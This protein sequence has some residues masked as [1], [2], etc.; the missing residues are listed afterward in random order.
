MALVNLKKNEIQAKIVYYGPGR[1][2]KTTNL[3]YIY[4]KSVKHINSEIVTINTGEGHTLFFDYLP[5]DIGAI[6]GFNLKVQLYTVPGQLK[7]NATR[8][9]LMRGV[10]GVVFVADSMAVRR[11]DNVLSLQ[12]LKEDL[13]HYDK[14]IEK[15]PLVI[16]YNKVDLIEKGIPLLNTETLENDLNQIPETP[17][18]KASARMGINV[19]STLKKIILTTVTSIEK[20]LN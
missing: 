14:R 15:T 18:Y 3:E 2:G 9:V 16:Q 20:D 17:Y 5:F 8:R 4:K 11:N 10:D 1:G 13:A 6:N 12:N 7:Y 19:I